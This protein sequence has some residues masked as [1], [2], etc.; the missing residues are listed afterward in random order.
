MTI[1]VTRNGKTDL[2]RTFDTDHEAALASALIE[3]AATV[4]GYTFTS[5]D[6]NSRTLTHPEG[7]TITIRLTVP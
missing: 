3:V 5:E 4:D 2:T 1:I 6:F 7:R